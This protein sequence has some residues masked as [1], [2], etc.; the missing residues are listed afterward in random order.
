[1][2]LI[3]Y[4]I[5]VHQSNQ[6]SFPLSKYS[7]PLQP[8]QTPHAFDNLY[9][10]I[11]GRISYMG[12]NY[13]LRLD[14]S[15]SKDLMLIKALRYSTIPNCDQISLLKVPVNNLYVKEFMKN[16]FPQKMSVFSF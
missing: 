14:L 7:Q 6:Q 12:S 10:F 8:P 3:Y 15:G 5:E 9:K 16:S 2:S 13:S 1:M 4:Q 11:K